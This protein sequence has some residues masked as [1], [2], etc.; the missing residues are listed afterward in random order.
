MERSDNPSVTSEVLAVA[1]S[2]PDAQLRSI[3]EGVLEWLDGPHLKFFVD[4][5]SELVIRMLELGDIADALVATNSLLEVVPDPRAADKAAKGDFPFGLRPEA[6][7]RL[8]DW[9]YERVLEAIVEPLVDYA[10]LEG[11]R[12]LSTLLATAQRLSRWEDDDSQ[13]YSYVWRPAIEDHEQNS[14]RSIRDA[15]VAATR[16]AA[17]RL[18]RQGPDQL[19]QVVTDLEGGTLIERRMLIL[20]VVSSVGADESMI[21]RF[22][23][24]RRLF[25]DHH[26]R[27][28]YSRLLEQR[29][30]DAS[31]DARANVIGWVYEG[32]DLDAYRS[33]AVTLDGETRPMTR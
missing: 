9:N 6:A 23:S 5:A 1:N 28:E 33:R 2:L 13:D 25:E 30:G 4:E 12:A 31:A 14:G 27:H 7:A 20:Y 16:D 17:L 10:G 8:S 18:A 15:L 19:V 32:P 21:S 3:V 24:D 26:V 11:L 22:V 29:F